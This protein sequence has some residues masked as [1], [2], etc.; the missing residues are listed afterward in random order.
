MTD[1]SSELMRRSPLAGCVLELSD[2]LFDQSFLRA[3]YDPN[4]GRCYQDVLSFD[5]VLRMMRD[6]LTRHGGSAHALFVELEADDTHPADESSFYRKLAKMPVAVSR[7]LLRE[8]AAKLGELMPRIN[9]PLPACFDSLDVVIADGKKIKDAARRLAP[10]R[11]Y[12]GALIGARALVAM[13]AR[14]GLV[15]AMSDSLDGMGNDSPLVPERMEQLTATAG[16]RPILSVWDRGFG[17][18]ATMRRMTTRPGDHFGVRVKKNHRFTAV[19]R[20][21]SS[22]AQGRKVIDETG[23]SGDATPR[24]RQAALPTRRITLQRS[25]EGEEDVIVVT[26]LTDPASYP[27]GDILELYARRW[28]IEQVFQQVTETFC[29]QHLIGASPKAVLLQFAFCLLLYDLMQ[30]IRAWLAD[31][32]AVATAIVSMHY[33]FDHTKRQLQA[34]A[35]HGQG[36]WPRVAGRT[37]AMRQ[38]L[39]ELLKGV[40]NA[41]RF[42]KAAD[43]KPRAK[44]KPKGRFKGGHSSIQRVLEGTAAIIPI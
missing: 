7:A 15:L 9:N 37:A 44:S 26:D 29:L 13:D 23:F 32:G 1:F 35:Y 25:G 30:V 28:G 43:K 39:G 4:R 3:I 18:P 31:D 42:T 36:H 34:W 21:E 17:E 24:A 41:K 6:A 2:Y 8:G 14:S 27:A 5:D 19:S 16:P 33:L 38:R 22:D 40:W 20:T 12:T 11:G 10:T